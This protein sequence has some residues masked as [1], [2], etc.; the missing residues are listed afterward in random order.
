[1]L[2]KYKYGSDD[3]YEKIRTEIRRSPL[4][5]FDWFI[6]SR[7]AVELNRRCQ[8]L[9]MLI[10]KEFGLGSVGE[11][12]KRPQT[13]EGDAPKQVKK[14]KPAPAAALVATE[15]SATSTA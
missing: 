14:K 8:T 11:Y 10:E 2:Q 12:R 13:A 15:V 5:R 1:M 4:F 3:I 9:I 7:S 6:K